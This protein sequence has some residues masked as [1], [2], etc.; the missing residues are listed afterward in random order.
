MR[1]SHVAC[2]GLLGLLACGGAGEPRQQP[3][4]VVRA[5]T[6]SGAVTSSPAGIV[7]GTSCLASYEVGT[8]VT[9][10]ADADASSA[11]DGWSG[12]GCTG[13]GPCIVTL[14]EALTVTASF[15]QVI[16]PPAD[17]VVTSGANQ[18]ALASTQVPAPIHVTVR[19]ANGIGVPQQ[20]VTFAV[21][22]G[23]GGLLGSS[24]TT[25]A[26]GTAVMPAWIVGRTA[27]PQVVRASVGTITADIG[28]AV[29]TDYQI[30]LRFHGTPMSESQE[31]A[32]RN[33]A[34]RISGIIIGDVID[35]DARNSTI[36]P[37]QCGV[38][39]QPNFDEIIDDV[40]IFVSI[41]FID[42]QGGILGQAGPCLVRDTPEGVMV[43]VGI[44]QFDAADVGSM[45]SGRLQD[46]ILHEMLHVVGIGTLW[47]DRGILTD[48]GSS[49]PRYTGPAAI[50]SCVALGG[51][52]A[53][54]ST[55]PV[56]NVGGAGTADSHW[57][58]STFRSELMT[59]GIDAG[60]NPLSAI[61]IGGLADLGFVVH[62]LPEDD[63]TV[64]ANVPLRAN[65]LPG[66]PVEK[67]ERVLQPIGRIE[68]G[69]LRPLSP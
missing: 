43:A 36:N 5:G 61:T 22:G 35:A 65:R 48:A 20:T 10:T 46:L 21:V 45:S 63:Y 12:A 23:G 1:L 26:T 7:C 55:V 66:P 69:V 42:G 27:I 68:H 15:T 62:T 24:A 51:T 64:F 33:A 11:F 39:D 41:Q 57:R 25:D 30:T 38:P 47:T 67:W 59:G 31:T 49:N 54:A 44:M 56:E 52:V 53:C 50:E 4:T 2:L 18:S 34:A 8:V 28:A 58:E 13:S 29:R 14:T 9:L 32:F 40:L 17:I 19:D 16:G 60:E 37:S 3:L 6:G